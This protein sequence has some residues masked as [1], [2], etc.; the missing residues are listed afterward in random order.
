MEN[1]SQCKKTN[2]QNSR[3]KNYVARY[4]DVEIR[5]SVCPQCS[6]LSFPKLYKV[7]EDK[8]NVEVREKDLAGCYRK[9]LSQKLQQG[10]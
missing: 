5:H 6:E 2:S 3:W 8:A 1:C 9:E 4:H 10:P 7:H